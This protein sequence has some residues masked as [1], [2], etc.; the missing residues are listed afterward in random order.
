MGIFDTMLRTHLSLKV[1]YVSH[2]VLPD[3]IDTLSRTDEG[4]LHIA[5]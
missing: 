2:I 3:P 4:S 1:R 5:V